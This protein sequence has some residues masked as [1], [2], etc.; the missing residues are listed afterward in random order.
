[1]RPSRANLTRIASSA[2]ILLFVAACATPAAQQSPTPGGS[3]G[4]SSS[5]SPAAAGTLG[6]GANFTIE[7]IGQP[8]PTNLGYTKVERPYTDTVWIPASKGRMKLNLVTRDERG[9]TGAEF[10]TLL[11]NQQVDI[12]YTSPAQIAGEFPLGEGLDLAGLSP[13]G[14]DA[15]K[16]AQA[17]MPAINDQL[18]AKGTGIQFLTFNPSVA[19]VIYCRDAMT[20]LSDL[21]GR[22]IRIFGTTLADFAKAVGAQPVDIPFADTY[23][24]LERGVLDCA[25]TGSATGNTSKWWEVTRYL[26]KIHLTWATQG[27]AVKT[28]WWN[29]LA[30]DVREFLLFHL[31]AISQQLTDLSDQI[32]SDGEFC[33]AGQADQCKLGVVPGAGKAMNVV[34][35]SQEDSA[36]LKNALQ[37]TIIPAYV[38]RCGAICGDLFNKYI[39]PVAG[40][41]FNK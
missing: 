11:A 23:S 36:F 20:K 28:S 15:R 32:T 29:G 17:F 30:A 27:Y 6:P 35:V 8:V 14:Q 39:A 13:T 2:F 24:A 18:A 3:T 34:G 4:A 5:A 41:Q 16:V 10:G 37:T 7:M 33:N 1:M 31:K 22:R 21:K 19:Q 26:Y 9:L 12:A 38:G 25:I 40:V